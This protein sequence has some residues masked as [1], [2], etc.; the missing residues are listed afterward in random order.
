VRIAGAI[1]VGFAAIIALA[2]VL[3]DV[4]W[5]RGWLAERASAAVGRSVD[6]G[7]GI[8]KAKF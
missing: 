8:V 7:E 5:L 4:N 2:V 6:I 1:I 3:F